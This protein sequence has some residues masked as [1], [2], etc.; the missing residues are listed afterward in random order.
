M[1][2]SHGV[3]SKLYII[4]LR[5]STALSTAS[6]GMSSNVWKHNKD[7][8]YKRMLRDSLRRIE[9]KLGNDEQAGIGSINKEISEN[10][11]RIKENRR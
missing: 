4:L 9:K 10:L 1:Y 2:F 3:E 11:K 8:D 7:I 5:S 6:E